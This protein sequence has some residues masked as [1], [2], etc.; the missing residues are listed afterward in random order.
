MSYR[1]YIIC[2]TRI[3]MFIYVLTGQ[4][5]RSTNSRRSGGKEFYMQPSAVFCDQ[6]L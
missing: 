5:W 1:N 4:R 6:Y 3:S 2:L